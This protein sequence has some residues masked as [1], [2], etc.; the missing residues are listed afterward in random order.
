MRILL[1]G[2]TNFG[3]RGCEA[4]VRSTSLMIN[5]KL[6]EATI[7]C[8][9]INPDQD[10]KQWSRAADFGVE[11]TLAPKFPSAYK[12]WARLCRV[13]PSVEKMGIP[14]FKLDSNTY[15]Q[16]KN[17]DHLIMTGGDILTLD[18]KVP[19]LYSWASLINQAMDMGVPTT[20]WAASVGPFS[21]IPH[22]EKAMVE[23]LK[24]YDSITVRES[25]SFEYLKKL[26][27][28][29]VSLVADPAF[30]LEPELLEN[31]DVLK[32][33][34]N[35]LGL[36]ISPLITKFRETQES[37]QQLDDEVIAFIKQTLDS[38]DYSILLIPHVDPLDGSTYNSDHHHMQ[39][40]IQALPGYSQ[41]LRL[42]PRTYNAGQLKHIISKC[43]FFIGA[44]THSTI[45]AF[46]MKVPT[47]SIAYSVKAKGINKDLFGS[48][49]YVLETPE[50]CNKTLS[51]YLTLLEQD[52]EEIIELL[53]RK[54]PEWKA[55]AYQSVDKLLQSRKV[56]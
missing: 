4:L 54:I 44:R 19:S 28:E 25:V 51:E 6:P 26:G 9:L 45:A 12:W 1:T 16:L 55:K 21:S 32:G 3:N 14:K 18:Y 50:V 42:L 49:K 36:N 38:S 22:V 20:L 35:I 43:R 40:Y 10:V 41:R 27:I 5:K 17:A 11:F 33:F 7:V 52:E 47:A 53:E 39:K 2:Q 24:R 46:S 23:H 34:H 30:N 31:E 15:N 13:V 37:K 48:T 29:N 56:S 8:P